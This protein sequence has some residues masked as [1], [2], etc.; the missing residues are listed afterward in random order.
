MGNSGQSIQQAPAPVYTSRSAIQ[1]DQL[2]DQ[3]W[4][5]VEQTFDSLD[6]SSLGPATIPGLREKL[7]QGT[8]FYFSLP[9]T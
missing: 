1:K 4:A 3:V 5:A 7:D 6:L 2:M 8:T 9:E